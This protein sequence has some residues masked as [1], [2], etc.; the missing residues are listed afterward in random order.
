LRIGDYLGLD[1]EKEAELK[2][3]AIFPRSESVRESS[4]P[5]ELSPF[6]R[7]MIQRGALETRTRPGED[8]PYPVS[9]GVCLSY[10]CTHNC[11]GCA[12]GADRKKE[13]AFLDSGSFEGLLSRLHSLKVRFIDL[14]GGG[15][16]TAHPEFHK[17]AQMCVKEGFDLSLL[18]NGTSLH[19]RT[20][21]LLVKGFSFLIINLDASN[22]EVYH[23]IH[24][25]PGPREFQKV[26]ANIDRVVRERDRVESKLTVGAQMRLCQ[27]NVNFMEQTTRLARDTGVDYVQFRIDRRAADGLLPDQINQVKNLIP[28]LRHEYAPFPVYGEIESRK[29]TGG[30]CSASLGQLIV[31]PIGDVYPCPHFARLPQVRSFGNVFALPPEGLWFGTKHKTV[32][33]RLRE[34]DCPIQDC[35]WRQYDDF[36]LN[37]GAE[38]GPMPT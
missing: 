6:D 30:R 37:S 14:R 27:S 31:N 19:S 38:S 12:H 11:S 4:R 9:A 32:V 5:E 15:E 3:I 1:A 28:D 18:T 16:P 23:Q 8:W 36:L 20:T 33:R 25:P 2:T 29:S 10:T 24:H 13:N 22:D 7:A 34:Y 17:F 26:L 21:R 35:R